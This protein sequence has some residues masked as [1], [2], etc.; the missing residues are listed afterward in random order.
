MPKPYLFLSAVLLFALAAAPAPGMTPQEAGS[1]AKGVAKA[2]AA[3][4][5][6]KEIYARD[7]AMCHGDTG[8]GQSDL[9]KDM[10]LTLKDWTDPKSLSEMSDQ[11]IFDM[12]RKGKD[13]M[14]PEDPGRAKDDEIKS[15]ILYIR[16]FS[17]NPPAA[18]AATPTTS[19]SA[20]TS[21]SGR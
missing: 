3:T 6:G 4:A 20:S 14:P 1:G 11:Q 9:A 5:K 2:A 17:K 21:G 8:N 7:C 18:P 12:I 15:I 13:K 19:T 10:Q 16:D